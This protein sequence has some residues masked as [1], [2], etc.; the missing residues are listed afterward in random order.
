MPTIPVSA[1]GE[2]QLTRNAATSSRIGTAESR[3]G[4]TQCFCEL[5]AMSSWA[6]RF[7]ATG[8]AIELLTVGRMVRANPAPA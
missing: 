5:N 2:I 3:S 4:A 1:S 8:M 6:I 7:W